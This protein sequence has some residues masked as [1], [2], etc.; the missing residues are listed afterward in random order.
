MDAENLIEEVH[1]DDDPLQE[2]MD[3]DQH[4]STTWSNHSSNSALNSI[5][6]IA[7]VNTKRMEALLGG[8]DNNNRLKAE[9]R[10]VAYLCKCQLKTLNNE[11]IDDVII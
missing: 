10:I 5:N 9:K 2:A 3:D 7:P 6:L 4:I 8:L 11:D 1:D